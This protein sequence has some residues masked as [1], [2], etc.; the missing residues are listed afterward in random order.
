MKKPYGNFT[1]V[2]HSHLPWVLSHGKWPHGTDWLNEAAAETYLPL[3]E[4]FNRLVDEDI[5]PKVTI[6]LSPVLTEQLAHED[7]KN[8]F[9]QYL[10]QKIEA[11]EADKEEFIKLVEKEKIKIAEY[12][13]NYYS[14]IKSKFQNKYNQNIVQ[15][16]KHLQ[17]QGH[18]EV[19]TCGATHGY[20]P[21]LSRDESVQAQVKQAIDNYEKHFG[22]K[23]KGIWLPECAYRPRYEWVPPTNPNK[24]PV[25]R[26]G[27]EEFLSENGIEFF[28]VDSHLL[29]GGEAIGV[30]LERFSTL[31]QVWGQ[32]IKSYEPINVAFEKHPYESHLVNSAT[33]DKKPVAFFTRDPKT[34]LQVWSG[35][36]GYPGDGNYLDF[37]KKHFPG[38][39]K[40]WRVTG[41]QVDLGDKEL[42]DLDMIQNRLE[43]NSDHFVNLVKEVLHDHKN[44]TGSETAILAA[45]FDTELFGHWWFEGV[46]WIYLVLKKMHKSDE[47]NLTTGSEH[48]EK[49]PP[50]NV[51]KLPEGSWGEGGFHYVWLNDDTK[52]TWNHIYEDEDKLISLVKHLKKS[53]SKMLERILKQLAREL[54][55]FQASD[56][57]FLITTVAARDYAETRLTRHHDYFKKLAKIADK[58]IQTGNIGNED[59]YFLEKLEE[60]DD[61]F[62]EIKLDYWEKVQFP[63]EKKEN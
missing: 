31:K 37:H 15:G 25:L 44:K 58:Y 22:R 41:S 6:G 55:L 10:D 14:D 29:T 57:Q 1:F 38:G 26:K 52:W 46:Q 36:H 28:V 45:P 60:M 47:I 59:M 40:Y 34:A 11:A 16:F 30:Y 32:F 51:V 35:E 39:H 33:E 62:Q 21:L 42:Y 18:I 20:F 4:A 23:P 5:S 12:W 17:D 43:E 24:K 50:K 9:I 3:L 8:E 2:L 61:I 63:A 53:P 49:K 48:L 56:W 19:I 27:V 13:I 54:F 7:F